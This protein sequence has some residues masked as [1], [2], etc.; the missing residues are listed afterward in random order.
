MASRVPC[1]ALALACASSAA[2]ATT[3]TSLRGTVTLARIDVDSRCVA[4]EKGTEALLVSC[5]EP[6]VFSSGS[7]TG[8]TASYRWTWSL[9]LNN[10]AV[11]GI[12]S[13]TGRL[14][15]AL[16]AGTLVLATNGQ[17]QPQ[18]TPATLRTRGG[19]RVASGTGRYAR[20]KGAGTFVFVSIEKRRAKPFTRTGSVA[21]SGTLS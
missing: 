1:F 11:S 12:G 14:T 16:R 13:E 19:W 2:A 3:F 17:T 21:L 4:S 7:P 20:A 9:V 15:L 8:A 6:G 18:G 10:G 5:T